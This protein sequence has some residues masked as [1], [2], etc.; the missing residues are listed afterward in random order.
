M[1]FAL[2]QGMLDML[3]TP[4]LTLLF[5][6]V[7]VGLGTAFVWMLWETEQMMS[8][9]QRNRDRVGQAASKK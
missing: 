4:T 9:S 6:G 2:H 8:R 1:Q 3:T 7:V 5:L